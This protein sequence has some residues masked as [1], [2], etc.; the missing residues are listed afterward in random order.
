MTVFADYLSKQDD[1]EVHLVLLSKKK[2]FF[3][4]PAN[5]TIHEPAA[6]NGPLAKM[7]SSVA[8]VRYVRKKLKALQP[9]ALLSFGSMFNSL[10]MLAT[11]GLGINTYLSD[12]SNPYRNT[13]LRFKKDAIERHDGAIHFFL[14]KILYKKATGLVVQTAMA[15]TIEEKFLGHKNIIRFPNPLQLTPPEKDL[16]RQRYIL[17]VGRFI[18]T[19][20]QQL[21]LEI[22]SQLDN[23]GW[24]LVFAGDGPHLDATQKRAAALQLDQQVI[25]LGNVPQIAD[26]YYQSEIFAFTSIT[27]GFPNALGE[28]LMVPLAA[29]SFD[30]VAGP[31]DLI[32]DNY[33]GYL[34]PV[35][36]VQQYKEKLGRL[37][38]D[39]VLRERFKK[40]ALEKMKE[41][42]TEQ[43]MNRL[44][45][46]LKS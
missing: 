11:T 43:N 28:A 20:Q 29:I 45:Q 37:M 1:V 7:F 27:E 10:V 16:P 38:Q 31:S 19:K 21:L 32:E 15:Q 2:Q 44:Y 5:V 23:A 36:D 12:R 40:N 26:Y 30:C 24:T 25:F 33:N 39:A 3:T 4:V 41:F 9:H 18:K 35:N 34:V 17:N 42:N 8:T 22:F 6:I 46:V 14:K 13:R